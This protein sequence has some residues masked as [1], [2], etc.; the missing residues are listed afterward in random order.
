MR[1]RHC[2]AEREVLSPGQGAAIDRV[3]AAYPELNDNAF[4]GPISRVGAADAAAADLAAG[5]SDRAGGAAASAQSAGDAVGAPSH[6][7]ALGC[8]TTRPMSG[9]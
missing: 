7:L 3:T 6:I 9:R 1:S 2:L 8:E 4:V 5:A